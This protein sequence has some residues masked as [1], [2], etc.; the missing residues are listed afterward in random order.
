MFVSPAFQPIIPFYPEGYQQWDP[1]FGVV[2]PGRPEIDFFDPTAH[3][4]YSLGMK[5]IPTTQV[6]SLTMDPQNPMF[7]PQVCY[8]INTIFTPCRFRA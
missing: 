8:T 5:T 4:A 1:S 2:G 3:D 6:P 7:N